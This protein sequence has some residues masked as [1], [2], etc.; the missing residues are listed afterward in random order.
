[1]V[2]GNGNAAKACLLISYTAKFLKGISPLSLTTVVPRHLWMAKP[3]AWTCG[4]W[5]INRIWSTENTLPPPDHYLCLLFSISNPSSYD[6]VRHKWHSEASHHCSNV[7]LLL[8][9]T[10]RDWKSDLETVK[11]LKQQR[12]VPTT[13]QQGTSLAKQVGAVKYLGCSALMQDGVFSEALWAVFYPAIKKTKKCVLLKL[14]GWYFGTA[15]TEN[16]GEFLWQQFTMPTEP[17]VSSS[18]NR[19]PGY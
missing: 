8:V 5:L 6:N 13:P 18:G 14:L 17:F 19:A 16:K 3:S 7:P 9:G 12:L 15:S 1:M 11:K 2:I 10:K 4:T